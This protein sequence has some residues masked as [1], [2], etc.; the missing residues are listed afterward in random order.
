VSETSLSRFLELVVGSAPEEDLRNR[1]YQCLT[2]LRVLQSGRAD[3]KYAVLLETQLVQRADEL[4]VLF[5]MEDTKPVAERVREAIQEK[6][7]P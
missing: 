7:S 2:M 3:P 6:A 4:A 1:A 5:G